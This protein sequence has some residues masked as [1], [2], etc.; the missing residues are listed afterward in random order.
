MSPYEVFDLYYTRFDSFQNLWMLYGTVYFG[1]LAYAVSSMSS[2]GKSEFKVNA[3]IISFLVFALF[4]CLVQ[5]RLFCEL[6]SLEE[7]A[8]L[9][10]EEDNKAII[11]S[12]MAEAFGFTD[13]KRFMGRLGF[14]SKYIEC[15]K[16]RGWG[17]L[18]FHGLFDIA[19]VFVLRFLFRR[20]RR[21]LQMQLL[22]E[23]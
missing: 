18:L 23:K 21:D 17:V 9:S 15:L 11:R 12:K 16:S 8:Q 3:I 14:S 2:L 7:I 5:V 6:R 19:L 22:K 4:N 20:S 1:V 10:L 13:D